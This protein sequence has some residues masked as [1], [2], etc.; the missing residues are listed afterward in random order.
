MTETCTLSAIDAAL[1]E[2]NGKGK[3]PINGRK[4][5]FHAGNQQCT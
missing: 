3:L 4:I 5:V 2:H 1:L